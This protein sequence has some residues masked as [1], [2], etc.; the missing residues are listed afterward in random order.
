M[1]Y[2]NQCSDDVQAENIID[3]KMEGM[4]CS[5]IFMFSFFPSYFAIC[6]TVQC[7]LFDMS[8]KI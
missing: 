4:M 2:N 3:K 7:E 5:L 6:W 1:F 8:L